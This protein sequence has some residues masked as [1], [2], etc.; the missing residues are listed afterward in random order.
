MHFNIF[1]ALYYRQLC[2]K[3]VA[4]ILNKKKVVLIG[5]T[6]LTSLIKWSKTQ[7]DEYYQISF[8]PL[9]YI[10]VTELYYRTSFTKHATINFRMS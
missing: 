7:R 6:Y 4:A 5:P 9:V 1:K 3:H 10:I 2:V 8:Y